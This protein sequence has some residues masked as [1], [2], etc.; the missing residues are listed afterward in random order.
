M[1]PS[2][3]A[4]LLFE[5]WFCALVFSQVLFNIISN[6]WFLCDGWLSANLQWQSCASFHKK[7]SDRKL[8]RNVTKTKRIL[9][10]ITREKNKTKKRKEGKKVGGMKMRQKRRR[11]CN[12][13][14]R[15]IV[16]SRLL[17]DRPK[18]AMPGRTMVQIFKANN[19]PLYF[20]TNKLMFSEREIVLFL[21]LNTQRL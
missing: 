18:K 2:T 19:A 20:E 3:R 10:K 9:R 16:N 11:K 7:Y 8:S 17:K 14:W 21:K 5:T 12:A 1:F 13:N 4:L 6:T 15:S